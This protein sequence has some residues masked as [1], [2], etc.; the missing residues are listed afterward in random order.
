MSVTSSFGDGPMRCNIHNGFETLDVEEWN[1]HCIETGHTDSGD[2][3]CTECGINIHFENIPFQKIT[4]KG[5]QISLKCTN[6]YGKQEDLQRMILNQGQQ[7]QQNEG[8]NI[9]Q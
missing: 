6:C 4:P 9:Q 3:Q 1:N 5:K 2:T 7:V 8:D